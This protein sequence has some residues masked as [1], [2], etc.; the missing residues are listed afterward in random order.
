MV[1]ANAQIENSTPEASK[2][3]K[4]WCIIEVLRRSVAYVRFRDRAVVLVLA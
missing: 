2:L 1:T 3:K 4:V